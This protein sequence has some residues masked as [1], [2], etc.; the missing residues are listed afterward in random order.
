MRYKLLGGTGIRVAEL[1]LGAMTFGT[2]WNW[3]SDKEESRAVFDVY[4]EAGGNFIDTANRYTEGTSE[5]FV[6]EFIAADREHFVVATKF[7]LLTRRGEPN[8]AG[9]GRKNLTESLDASLKRLGTDY[10]DLYWVHAWDFTTR[11]QELM[12]AL[13]DAVRQGK[14]LSIGISDTPA[15]IV[16]QANTIAEFRG[17]TSFAGLQIEYSLAQR[18]VERELLPMAAA[19]GMTVCA[20]APLAAGVLT[21]KYLGN[22]PEEDVRLKPESVRLTERNYAIAHEVA[23]VAAE[24]GATPAQVA[25]A[26]LRRQRGVI[27]PILGA[28]SKAQLADNLGCLNVELGAEHCARLDAVSAIEKGFPHEFLTNTR[29]IVFGGLYDRIDNHLL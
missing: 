10:I 19:F 5:R 23:A 17:W 8:A 9:N 29:E 21:G 6:G 1:C 3:G 22:R 28:R 13:D 14:I 7:T 4:A 25:I 2:E 11:P 20:W 27:I 15:W 16:A 18:T 26:W 12:R 24:L